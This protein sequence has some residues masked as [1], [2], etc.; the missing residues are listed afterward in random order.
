MTTSYLTL[1]IILKFL[2]TDYYQH[3]YIYD[4]F[5]NIQWPSE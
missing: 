3:I 2:L 4:Q 5:D 1:K